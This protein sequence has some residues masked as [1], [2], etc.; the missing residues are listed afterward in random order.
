MPD[1]S[2]AY[3]LAFYHPDL[4]AYRECGRAR[5]RNRAKGAVVHA[6]GHSICIALLHV[7][8]DIAPG[9]RVSRPEKR[10]HGATSPYCLVGGAA[11]RRPGTARFIAHLAGP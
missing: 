11:C 4:V 9:D 7:L 2:R 3:E 6:H 1:F 5:P 8:L 10:G